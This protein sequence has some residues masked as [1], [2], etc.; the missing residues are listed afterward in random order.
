M[1][2]DA[3]NRRRGNAVDLQVLLGEEPA[4]AM[5]PG[6][7]GDALVNSGDESPMGDPEQENLG[8]APDTVLEDEG[9]ASI[10]AKIAAMLGRDSMLAKSIKPKGS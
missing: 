9:E 8:L 1:M 2:K 3:L 4:E 10:L 6:A 5:V 7:P